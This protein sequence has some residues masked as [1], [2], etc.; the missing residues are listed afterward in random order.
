MAGLLGEHKEPGTTAGDVWDSVQ[1]K[2]RI[3][4]EK[5][6]NNFRLHAVNEQTVSVVSGHT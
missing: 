5:N 2:Y 3:C 6:N 1:M 4:K